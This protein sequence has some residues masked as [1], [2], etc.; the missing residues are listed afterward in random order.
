MLA[1]PETVGP[2]A[3]EKDLAAPAVPVFVA[4][5][6]QVEG[7]CHALQREE[8]VVAFLKHRPLK[9]AAAAG[10]LVDGPTDAGA[11]SRQAGPN[12][13]VLARIAD[14][15]LPSGALALVRKIASL[16]TP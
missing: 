7:N 3:V 9:L 8:I 16:P 6:F 12:L 2:L 4:D 13:R 10:H 5:G 14:R 11:Q 1:L 15:P